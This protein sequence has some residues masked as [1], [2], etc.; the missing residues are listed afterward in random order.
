MKIAAVASVIL[1]LLASAILADVPRLINYQG[2][3]ITSAG[4]P[5]ADGNHSVTFSLYSQATGGAALWTENQTISTSS[6]LF[7]V[8]LGSNAPL[9]PALFSDSNR[10]LGI[11]I[12]AD[13]ELT[14]RARLVTV[15]YALSADSARTVSDKY[16]RLL[17]DTM[18]GAIAI[19]QYGDGNEIQ[20]SP[21][22]YYG[23]LQ[24][25]KRGHLLGELKAGGSTG[26][27]N[28]F[29]T[30][31]GYVA[32]IFGAGGGQF[33]LYDTVGF[34]SVILSAS[35]GFVLPNSCIRSR[36]IADEPGLASNDNTSIVVLS[37]TMQD[38]VTT[39]ITS[40]SSGYVYLIAKGTGYLSGTTGT[41]YA[42]VQ[43]SETGGGAILTPYRT[44]FGSQA[45]G[46]TSSVFYPFTVTRVFYKPDP[47]T[48]TF[49]LEG[50]TGG[51]QGSGASLDIRNAM[52][53]A[54][55]FPTS[56][57]SVNTLVSGEEAGQ[58]EKAA[59]VQVDGQTGYKVDLRELELKAA[60]A[61]AEAQKARLELMDAQVRQ[62]KEASNGTSGTK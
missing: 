38:I 14:P 42:Y 31:N 22:A 47:G 19:D 51:S 18:T 60:R 33:R 28:L 59:P 4:E 54:M 3:L 27:L 5:I 7:A 58:F 35:G 40:P 24:V 61:E 36:H 41:N 21:D 49:R 6:G 52:I 8:L 48:F 12:G 10:Y 45:M 30:T 32:E 20:I 1:V 56:Y 25:L 53:Q 37:T 50:C 23:T 2:R 16:L 26:I 13:P 9:T 39:S 11:K 46:T 34:P 44:V 17:G 15:P 55:Y 43:I 29:D 57:G 62:M